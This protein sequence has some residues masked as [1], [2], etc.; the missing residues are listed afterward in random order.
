MV[1]VRRPLDITKLDFE[2]RRY[3]RRRTLF[4][5]SLPLMLV[6]VG[7]A[8]WLAL[9]TFA[10]IVAIQ[11]TDRG[12]Y[13]TAEQWLNYAAYGTVLEKYKVP[14]NKAIV[15]VHQ[16]QFD[17]AIEEVRTAIV[18]A[19]E[20]PKCFI[21]TQSVLATELAGDDAIARAKP[22]EAI[23]Y[24]TKAIG[25]IRANNDCF[26]EYE[27][28]S[29][30]IAEKLSAVT[31][32]I[33]KKSYQDPNSTGKEVEEANQTPS[34]DQM[35]KLDKLIEEGEVRRQESDYRSR[36]ADYSIKKPW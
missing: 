35:D 18:G 24:Y 1:T 27:K 21:R 19:P 13:T 15:A 16:K 17:L 30:R 20:D 28:L 2:A 11:A 31:N 14:F 12:D 5:W 7:L 22:E 10:T 29:M 9:P 36:E 26:K 4:R 33:K 32:A 25:E 6:L 34:K 8:C 3:A 23:Q